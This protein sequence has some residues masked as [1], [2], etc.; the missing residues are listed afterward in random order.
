MVQNRKYPVSG[1]SQDETALLMPEVK[2]AE[3][4][5]LI[6]KQQ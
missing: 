2:G 4:F 1:S 3:C 5:E 6:G